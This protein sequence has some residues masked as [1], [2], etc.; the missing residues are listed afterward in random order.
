MILYH[1]LLITV[2]A[3]TCYAIGT[4]PNNN[5]SIPQTRLYARVVNALNTDQSAE[6]TQTKTYY[7]LP[8]VLFWYINPHYAPIITALVA[9]AYTARLPNIM[10]I[11]YASGGIM[12][13]AKTGFLSAI[14]CLE[15]VSIITI[16]TIFTSITA[17]NGWYN[18]V[19]AASILVVNL[20]G[21]G[22]LFCTVCVYFRT[23]NHFL[24]I[25]SQ[26]SK[27]LLVAYFAVKFGN[28]FL[29]GT[30]K[31]FYDIATPQFILMVSILQFVTVPSILFT[32]LESISNFTDWTLIVGLFVLNF[33][34]LYQ[35]L[36]THR[37]KNLVL[38]TSALTN[39]ISVIFIVI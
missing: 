23:Q 2:T 36:F 16:G 28:V 12:L 14:I 6:I 33:V 18:S 9:I 10:I 21:Y 15:L 24:F 19:H 34:G 3:M 31:I 17:R 22:L 27:T 39:L 26:T 38:F 35:M 4:E 29:Y 25:K 5:T 8:L 30:K 20:L 37:L 7:L 13:V 11:I 1:L 32:T